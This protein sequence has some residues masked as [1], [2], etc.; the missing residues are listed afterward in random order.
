ADHS[1]DDATFTVLDVFRA[2][3][4]HHPRNLLA[5]GT[6]TVAAG[7]EILRTGEAISVSFNPEPT[8]TA[9]AEPPSPLAPG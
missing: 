1:V 2:D 5:I 9:R 7:C 3:P 4:G 8:A 6:L